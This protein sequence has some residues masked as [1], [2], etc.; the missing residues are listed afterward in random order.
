MDT[1]GKTIRAMLKQSHLDAVLTAH[2]M[3]KELQKEGM[4]EV[5]I[6]EMLR[7]NEFDKD[8]VVEAISML[9]NRKS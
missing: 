2:S 1:L 5:Q 7:A 6:D 4:T 9:S 8:V 3:A